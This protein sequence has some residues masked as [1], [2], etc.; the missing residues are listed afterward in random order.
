M[1]QSVPAHMK[2]YIAPF[3]AQH[4]GGGTPQMFSPVSQSHPP[5]HAFAAHLPR[6][7][8]QAGDAQHFQA[9]PSANYGA[10]AVA[11]APSQPAQPLQ[12]VQAVAP[13]AQPGPP[14]STPA[15]P[16]APDGPQASYAAAPGAIAPV[17]DFITN[18]G[19]AAKQSNLPKI[20]GTSNPIFSRIALVAGGLVLLLVIGLIFKGILTNGTDPKPYIISVAQ[21]Q[22]SIVHLTTSADLVTSL[23]THNRNFAITA[24]L[25]LTSARSETIAYLNKIGLKKLGPQALNLKINPKLDAE[26][27]TAATADNYNPTFEE[28][29]KTQLTNY[30]IALQTAYKKTA[31]INGRKL[32]A[33]QFK[34]SELLQTQLKDTT[35]TAPAP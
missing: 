32:L 23:S 12:P 15:T 29:M 25:S 9:A 16:G 34:Q 2:Q 28:I 22:Q 10:A 14:P 24:Q 33:D 19:H 11:P 18:P 5:P 20:P 21:S 3:M 7:V 4:V 30:Q 35:T 6:Q 27:A 31:G 13:V 17:Y 1:S 8:G 26:L